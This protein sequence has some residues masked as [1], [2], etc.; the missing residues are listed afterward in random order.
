MIGTRRFAA[1]AVVEGEDGEACAQADARVEVP[2]LR[3][4]RGCRAMELDH[5]AGQGCETSDGKKSVTSPASM[6]TS[7]C[8]TS[9]P[10]ARTP[11]ARAV[12][13]PSVGPAEGGDQLAR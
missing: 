13:N 12:T 11:G 7:R 1:A 3:R 9:R 10:G 2:L 4:R 6:R 5:G 8:S